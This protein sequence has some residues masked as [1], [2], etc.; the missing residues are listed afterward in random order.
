MEHKEDVI[1]FGD[2]SRFAI[3]IKNAKNNTDRYYFRYYFNNIRIG[4]FKKSGYMQSTIANFN[5][6][7]N[8]IDNLYESKFVYMTSKEVFD[9]IFLSGLDQDISVEE[10]RLLIERMNRYN[11]NDDKL[12]NSLTIGCYNNKKGCIV[13]LIYKMDGVNK[14]AFYSFVVEVDYFKKVYEELIQYLT[15]LTRVLPI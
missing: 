7:I 15:R 9:D 11:F 8:K 4:D 13:F 2:K 5:G 3:E 6:L 12:G 1:Y 14:P 10:E